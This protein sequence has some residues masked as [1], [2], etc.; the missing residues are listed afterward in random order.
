MVVSAALVAQ[1]PGE[2]LKI[3]KAQRASNE[4]ADRAGKLV[5]LDVCALCG[6]GELGIEL[7]REICPKGSDIPMPIAKVVATALLNAK[8]IEGAVKLL[9]E[10]EESQ[11][12]TSPPD[13]ALYAAVI[14]A[15]V[16][17]ALESPDDK[18]WRNA[19]ELFMTCPEGLRS[20][21]MLI[22]ERELRRRLPD[23]VKEKK[24]VAWTEYHISVRTTDIK[25]AGTDAT[26]F[27]TLYNAE[28]KSTGKLILDGSETNDDPFERNKVDD[29]TVGGPWIGDIVKATIGHDDTGLGPDWHCER[30]SVE[31]PE[32]EKVFNFTVNRWFSSRRDDNLCERTVPAQFSGVTR[33]DF[34]FPDGVQ[35]VG[36][37]HSDSSEDEAP[38][39]NPSKLV[40]PGVAAAGGGQLTPGQLA[41]ALGVGEAGAA[42]TAGRGPRNVSKL[43]VRTASKSSVSTLR[44]ETKTEDSSRGSD[45]DTAEDEHSPSPRLPALKQNRMTTY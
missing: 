9:E 24:V 15:A 14:S 42:S 12:D 25:H 1:E 45:G 18:V 38:T 8:N 4:P 13:T 41:G 6:E 33:F 26:V 29:F 44:E 28:G 5:A 2:A 11:S 34:M 31:A 30:F 3:L 7:L 20:L 39:R 36:H 40:A 19:L 22:H 37:S 17:Q 43:S 16:V 21:E 23:C 10:I 32:Q 27:V 35:I